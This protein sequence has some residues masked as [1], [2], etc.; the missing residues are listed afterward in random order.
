MA[1]AIYS[2]HSSS[3]PAGNSIT[4][5]IWHPSEDENTP[6]VNEILKISGNDTVTAVHILPLESDIYNLGTDE[7]RWL[8]STGSQMY[9]D[10]TQTKTLSLYSGT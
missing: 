9:N 7:K 6:S 10:T 4:F 8:L 5:A 3:D 2:E 1:D